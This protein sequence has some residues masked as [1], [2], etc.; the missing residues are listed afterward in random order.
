MAARKDNLLMGFFGN[1]VV[2]VRWTSAM[3]AISAVLFAAAVLMEES[4]HQEPARM[5]A[6]DEAAK[7]QDGHDEPGEG[8]TAKQIGD[9]AELGEAGGH[10]ES[11][12]I[13]SQA[14][15][16]ETGNHAEQTLLG[17]NL[18]TPWLAWGFIGVSILLAAGVMRLGAVGNARL[19]LAILLAGVA[20]VLDGREVFLQLARANASVAGLAALTALAHA[21][22]V[23]LAVLAWQAA[24]THA[25]PAPRR[26]MQ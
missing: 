21:A 24:S 23:I 8:S 26:S 5:A 2:L 6:H 19:L 25:G 11:G 18:E 1:R 20:A 17:I 4:G 3:L 16:G 14:E 10:V 7:T 13:G 15:S 9:S 12:E 22:V